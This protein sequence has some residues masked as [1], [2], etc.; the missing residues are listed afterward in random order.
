MKII[1]L[2]G[3]T[4]A[5][6]SSIVTI[7]KKLNIKVFNCDKI[8]R[9]VTEKG[10]PALEKLA[11]EFGNDILENGCLIRSKLAQKA[12]ASKEETEKLNRIIFPFI[13]KKLVSLITQEIENGTKAVLLDAPTLYESGTD[14]LC[15]KVI[16]VL[17]S[18]EIRQKR[19]IKRDNLNIQ[20]AN[21]RMNAGKSD[22]FYTKADYIIN[23]NGSIK[24][25]LDKTEDI[26]ITITGGI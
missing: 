14:V 1:G 11:E 21:L 19:I 24:E 16:A 17:S 23:N 6:K 12:F 13:K 8:A 3:P 25:F 20:S 2:T 26:L 22:N 18:K 15:D 9:E 7:A 10:Q 5:G 4:G